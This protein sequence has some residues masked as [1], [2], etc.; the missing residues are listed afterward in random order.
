MASLG[1]IKPP[2]RRPV[3]RVII[4]TKYF[5]EFRLAIAIND[6]PS[7]TELITT[8]VPKSFGLPS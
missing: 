7:N 6:A 8:I 2:T 4:G 1:G 5:R 3:P